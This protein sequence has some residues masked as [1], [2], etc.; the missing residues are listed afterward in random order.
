MEHDVFISHASEDKEDFVEPLATALIEAGL[1]VW[2]DRF[3]LKLGDSLREKIDQGLANSRYGVVV[4]SRAFFSKEWPKSELDALVTRQNSE[5]KKVILPIWHNVTADEVRRFSPILASKMA[6]RS[7]DGIEA[8]VAQIVDICNEA[9]TKPTSVFQVG[10]SYGLREQCLEIIRRDDIIAWRKLVNHVSRPIPDQLIEWKQ[11][12]EEAGRADGAAW[13]KA[14]HNAARICLPG[15]VPILSSVEAGNLDFWKESVRVLQR[16]ALLEGQM[17]GGLCIALRIG[18]SMLSTAGFLGLSI[19][20]DLR[21]FDL[22][23]NWM[24]LRLPGKAEG[25]QETIWLHSYAANRLPEGIPFDIKNPFMFFKA[26][27]T[28]DLLKNFFGDDNKLTTNIFA[29]SLLT[30]LIDLRGYA[31]DSRGRK[32][33]LE[34]TQAIRPHGFPFW[35]MLETSQFQTISLDLFGDSQSAYAYVFPQNEVDIAT[36]WQLW[37]Q[38]R[39][40]CLKCWPRNL[41]MH[42]RLL[43][44]MSLPGEPIEH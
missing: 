29:A 20:A 33:L 43:D 37:K 10:Q 3:E 11:Q 4:L 15:F 44:Y 38:W 16:L 21:L 35:L 6:A 39:I 26:L 42:F 8:V 1:K 17:G 9:E 5:G 18:G 41:G 31:M 30:S 36:F 12:G 25:V 23:N 34:R 19:A 32:T 40:A 7:S 24:Y 14:V 22:V 27:T 28:E 2:Y 13:E